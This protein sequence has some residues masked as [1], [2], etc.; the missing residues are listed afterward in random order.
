[1]FIYN[2][3]NKIDNIDTQKEG[4]LLILINLVYYKWEMPVSS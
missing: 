3:Y 1:M 4:K 2:K